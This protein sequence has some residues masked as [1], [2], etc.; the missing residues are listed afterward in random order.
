MNETISKVEKLLRHISNVQEACELLG[1]KL[2]IKGEIELGVQLIALGQ[3]HDNSKWFGIEWDFIVSTPEFNE[4][5]KLAAQHHNRTNKH[6]P[7]FWGNI[8]LMP[9]LY[10][11]E[12]CCDWLSRANEFGTN[13]WEYVK[14]KAIP[15]YEISP[16]GKVYKWIKEFFDMLLEKPF[17]ETPIDKKG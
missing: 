17:I 15:R 2:I 1:R 4:M 9:R 10:I 5:A 3:I 14:E 16:N 11:A 8:N 13:V 7:E 6:H 12:M